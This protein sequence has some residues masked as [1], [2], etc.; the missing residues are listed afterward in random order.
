MVILDL[1]LW[2]FIDEIDILLI[3]I[4]LFVGLMMWNMVSVMD[5]FL[6]LVFLIMFI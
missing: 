3:L 1:R 5:D 6:V 4:F 2:S